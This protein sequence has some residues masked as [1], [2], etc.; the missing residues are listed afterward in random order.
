MKNILYEFKQFAIKGNALDL[1]IAV[2][3]G[4]AFTNIVNSIV[5]DLI[6]PL[7]SL[8]S[9]K[10]DFSNSYIVIHSTSTQAF[11]TLADAKAAGASTLN[12]GIFI[13]NVINFFIVSFVIFLIVKQINRLRRKDEAQ[14]AQDKIE[15]RTS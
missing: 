11:K 13:N 10:I 6:N 15:E 2:V 12:Y 8:I 5:N 1:A 4:A 9:G 14:K 3:I 7:I